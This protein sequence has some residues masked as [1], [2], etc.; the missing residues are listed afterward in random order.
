MQ[1]VE[2]S[3]RV[4][5]F[6][7]FELDLRLGELRREG[8]KAV[9]LSEQPFRILTMLLDRPGDL[10]TREEIRSKL[11]PDGTIVEFEHSISAAMNRLRQALG[12]SPENP[13]YV[14]T[15]ARRGYRWKIPV[16]WV[17]FPLEP[18]ASGAP[19]AAVP[20]AA[21]EQRPRWMAFAMLSLVLLSA[22]GY[23]AWERFRPRTQPPAGKIMLAVL[24]FQNLT[25]DPG[26]EYFSDGL[27]EE[28]ITVLGGLQPQRLGVIARTSVMPYKHADK[29][30][31]RIG[32]ELQVQYLL[33][34]SVLQDAGRVRITAQ[35]I[36]VKD[37]THLWAAN[38]QRDLRDVLR[39]QTDVA[40][41][42]AEQIQL[43]L[44]APVKARLT[45]RSPTNPEAYR[46]YLEGRYYT[47][48][49][50]KEGVSKGIDCFR[51]AIQLDPT[52]A[53]AYGGLAF[54]Y[55]DGEDDFFLA[56]RESMPM[57]A[58]AAKMALELDDTLPEAHLEM[59]IVH[60]WYDYDWDA[61]GK[62]LRQAVELGPNYAHA[63]EYYGWYLISLG[64]TAEGIAESKLAMELD[65]LSSQVLS[66]VGA[67][68]YFARRY[69]LAMDTLLKLLDVDPDYW[70]GRMLLGLTYEARGDLSH[71]L[72]E[73]QRA[74][75]V[76]T[77]IPWPSAELGHAFAIAGK[78]REAEEIL[79]TLNQRPRESYV[80]PYN[81]AEIYIGLGNKE[82][83]LASL[84][85]AYADRSM[86]LT[87]LTVDPEFDGLHSDPRFR[88]LARRV[89]LPQ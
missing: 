58:Q 51:R 36:Q 10:V 55:S 81:L 76:Q 8:E 72:S 85:Q 41:A 12:D 9:Q 80:P 77:T 20:R 5:R 7:G 23:F 3:R 15:L 62:E 29:P 71:A 2:G 87:F 38:Y 49:F 82:K 28:M 60:Y 39:I 65:P 48:K 57:A 26:Q 22:T 66:D 18:I 53:L 83:A 27:T 44:T 69:D 46:L 84:E 21:P 14:E 89:G 42:I 13:R 78:K 43:Q 70:Y 31:S 79:K 1:R 33:E 24:P 68:F 32:R 4:A 56:P 64:R 54:A 25:G 50:T 30:V 35:L 73:C 75:Q 37:Q 86:F 19:T 16:Q 63:H 52:Y 61:A 40:E 6:E 47:E 11:W 88:A 17:E 34:G 67:N 59:G 45:K 74:V